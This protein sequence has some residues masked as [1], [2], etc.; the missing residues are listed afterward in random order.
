MRT[1]TLAAL[2]VISLSLSG[3]ST[4]PGSL[5]TRSGSYMFR[6]DRYQP[7]QAREDQNPNVTVVV[8]ISG[9]GYRAANLGIG[10]LAALEDIELEYGGK[11]S[12]L[13]QEV[14]YFTT[15]SGGGFAAGTYLTWLLSRENGRPTTSFRDYILAAPTNISGVS[16][17]LSSLQKTLAWRIL[18]YNF[19]PKTY[20]P[21]DRGDLLQTR[22]DTTVLRKDCDSSY[23][24]DYCSWSL[25]DIFRAPEDA[26][27]PATP[28]WIANAT[29]YVNGEIFSF[30]PDN[31][32][33]QGV[34][35]FTHRQ[36]WKQANRTV[37]CVNGLAMNVPLALGMRSSANFPVGIPATTLVTSSGDSLKLSDGGQAD[38]LAFY[39][40]LEILFQEAENSSH[41]DPSGQLLKDHRR[42]LIIVDAYRGALGNSHKKQ[43][44][45]DMLS[46]ALRSPNLP[47]DALRSRIK[48]SVNASS[49]SNRSEVDSVLLGTNLAVAYINIDEEKEA[50]DIGT[51]FWLDESEQRTL[52]EAGYRQASAVLANKCGSFGFKEPIETP[53]KDVLDRCSPSIRRGTLEFNTG[54]ASQRRSDLATELSI[55]ISALAQNIADLESVVE[56]GVDDDWRTRQSRNEREHLAKEIHNNILV[57]DGRA[58]SVALEELHGG[59]ALLRALSGYAAFLEVASKDDREA[60]REQA[61]VK[62]ACETLAVLYSLGGTYDRSSLFR[63]KPARGLGGR[64]GQQRLNALEATSLGLPA[65]CR[66]LGMTSPCKALDDFNRDISSAKGAYHQSLRPVSDLMPD[67]AAPRVERVDCPIARELSRLSSQLGETSAIAVRLPAG[68]QRDPTSE[69]ERISKARQNILNIVNSVPRTTPQVM[70][71]CLVGDYQLAE[72]IAPS[73]EMVDSSVIDV[74]CLLDALPKA[75]PVDNDRVKLLASQVFDSKSKDSVCGADITAIPRVSL[76]DSNGSLTSQ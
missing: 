15:V 33:S 52:I 24:S 29:N 50:R 30:T 40:A 6:L 4:S 2:A 53:G 58:Y 18:G 43:G 49:A 10:A 55:R 13:L 59:A 17:N 14:D 19:S 63:C 20:G 44:A 41:V 37:N 28:Y 34:T 9:G 67:F 46:A 66:K 71:D 31:I 16:N 22:L 38:N 57:N 42:L 75:W 11:S 5:S 39:S 27:K 65:L 51:T 56:D 64:S 25:G 35:S 70:E 32:C 45:P 1:Q 12:N 7:V 69:S 74:I 3:C 23:E 60:D 72:R 48:G 76:P 73:I 47:L 36:R 21:L 26:R 61:L 54:L 8:A 68:R 62:L